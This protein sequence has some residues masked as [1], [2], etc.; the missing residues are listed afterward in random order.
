MRLLVF[1]LLLAAVSLRAEYPQAFS[2]MGSMYDRE[3]DRL[4]ALTDDPAFD[5]EAV[6]VYDDA[7]Q[8]CFETGYALDAAIEA[9]RSERK[10]LRGR[11]L[12]CLRK[13]R[14]RSRVWRHRYAQA[15]DTAIETR[16]RKRF[17]RLVSHALEPLERRALREK[18]LAYYEGFRNEETIAAMEAIRDDMRIE[19]RSAAFLSTEKDAF[20]KDQDVLTEEEVRQSDR[21]VLVSTERQGSRFLFYAYNKNIY[22]VTLTLALPE[23]RNFRASKPLPIVVELG[24]YEKRQILQLEISDRGRRASFSSRYGWVMGRLSA[25]HD[26]PLYRLPFAAGRKVVVS[27]GF[28]GGV[29]HKGLTRYAVD[30]QCPE[31]TKIYAARGGKVIA[32]ESRHNEG[33]FDERFGDKANYIIIEHDDGTLG[34]YYHLKQYGVMVRV[35]EPVYRGQFIGYSGNTGYSSGPHLHFSVSSVD[36]ASK[37]LPITLPFRFATARGVVSAPKTGDVYTVKKLR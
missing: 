31:G 32:A 23:M 26:D 34:K 8:A 28:D 12:G 36:P 15:L 29:T 19:E 24:P 25:R 18:A 1:L 7:R 13:L 4:K 5:R 35:G 10:E 27:Q 33:G 9:G 3:L 6:E 20:V 17:E 2:A 11:Y 37:K 22:P 14:E 16:D 30:F 21:P